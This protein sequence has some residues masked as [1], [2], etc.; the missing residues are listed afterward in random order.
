MIG[1][2]VLTLR[3]RPGL[4]KQSI[5]K[6]IHVEASKSIEKKKIKLRSGIDV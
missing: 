4:K 2:I 5:H 3:Q 6:Q 1:S